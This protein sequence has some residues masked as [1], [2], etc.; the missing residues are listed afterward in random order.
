MNSP[1]NQRPDDEA[2]NLTEAFIAEH[3]RGRGMA[4]TGSEG[5]GEKA[6]AAKQ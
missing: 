2:R 1:T 4:S 3:A 6:V 5:A